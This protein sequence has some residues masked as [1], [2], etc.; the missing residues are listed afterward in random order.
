VAGTLQGLPY[1]DRTKFKEEQQN[2]PPKGFYSSDFMRRGEFTSTIRTEQYR[3]L[4]K[5]C[6]FPGV[7]LHES[8]HLHVKHEVVPRIL[9][10]T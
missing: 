9:M 5:A 10:K 7:N 4:L 1:V 6:I 2:R 8:S 3:H